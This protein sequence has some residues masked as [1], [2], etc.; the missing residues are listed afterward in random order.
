MLPHLSDLQTNFTHMTPRRLSKVA[1][2]EPAAATATGKGIGW[3]SNS[4]S[5]AKLAAIRLASSLVSGLAAAR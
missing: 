4:G 1:H 2:S 5:L 3:R